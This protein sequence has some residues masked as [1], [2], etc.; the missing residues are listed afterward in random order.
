MKDIFSKLKNFLSDPSSTLALIGTFVVLV[1]SFFVTPDRFCLV[2]TSFVAFLAVIAMRAIEVR[3]L[4]RLEDRNDV[5]Q[6]LRGELQGL[7]KQR[8][9]YAAN[10]ESAMGQL[11][12]LDNEYLKLAKQHNDMAQDLYNANQKVQELTQALEAKKTQNKTARKKK[13]DYTEQDQARIREEM[14]SAGLVP[15]KED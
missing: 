8:S 13:E 5:I 12:A 2:M 3:L 11:Q 9:D 4:N 6:G 14:K 10:H 1:S 7:R 15:E